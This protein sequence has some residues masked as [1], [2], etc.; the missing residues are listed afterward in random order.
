MSYRVECWHYA[1]VYR[2]GD[3]E[4]DLILEGEHTLPTR[5]EAKQLIENRLSKLKNVRREYHKGIQPSVCVGWTGKRW[6]NENT[7]EECLEFYKYILRKL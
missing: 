1:K 2:K 5:K 7:G 4:S 6:T 3:L